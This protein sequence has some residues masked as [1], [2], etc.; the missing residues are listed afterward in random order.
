VLVPVVF[1]RDFF[2]VSQIESVF[3]TAGLGFSFNSMASELS[4]FICFPSLSMLLLL[5]YFL[6]FSFLLIYFKNPFDVI[7]VEFWERAAL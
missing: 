3:S 5:F 7:L 6:F 4:L 1:F 2:C